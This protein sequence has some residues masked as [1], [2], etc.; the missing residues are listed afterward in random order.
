MQTTMDAAAACWV[1]RKGARSGEAARCAQPLRGLPGVPGQEAWS[2]RAD[3]KPAVRTSRT[4][5]AHKSGAC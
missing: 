4:C 1:V 3:W 2:D 5:R